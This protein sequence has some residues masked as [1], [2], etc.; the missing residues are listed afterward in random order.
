MEAMLKKIRI[1]NFLSIADS[2]VEL[3]DF[4]I[5]VGPNA[6]GKSNFLDALRFISD[7]LNTSIYKAFK[8]RGGLK[9]VRRISMG[10]PRNIQF[11]LEFVPRKGNAA[12]YGF[13]IASDPKGAFTVK[14]EECKIAPFFKIPDFPTEF[15][16]ENGKSKNPIMGREFIIE[17]DSLALYVLKIFP[18]FRPLY[19]FLTSMG[20]YSIAPSKLRELQEPDVERRLLSDGSNAAEILDAIKKESPP[21]YSRICEYLEKIVPGIKSVSPKVVGDKETLEFGQDVGDKY[22][23]HFAALNM[24]DG[25]L[26][27]VGILIAIFQEPPLPLVAIEEPEATIHPAAIGVLLDILKSGRKRSQIVITTHSPDILDNKL[28]LP[29]DIRI[30]SSGRGE[31]RISPLG[32]ISLEAV[33][34]NLYSFGELMRMDELRPDI[35]RTEQLQITRSPGKEGS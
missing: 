32:G 26:R 6:S 14:K 3:S 12:Y 16:F 24:S 11:E 2:T 9:A 15:T 23:W 5:L 34:N 31:T 10:H 28:I 20:F 17:K 25:T 33:R 13:E 22:P 19:D 21:N 8:K 35:K 1:K 18:T 30:V 4:T 7:C 29:E 27:V